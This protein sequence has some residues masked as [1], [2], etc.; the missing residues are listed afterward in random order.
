M[1]PRMSMNTKKLLMLLLMNAT[2]LVSC[3]YYYFQGNSLGRMAVVFIISAVVLN[4]VF[5]FSW[6]AGINKNRQPGKGS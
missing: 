5:V 3:V 1:V 2:V 4:L 6:R